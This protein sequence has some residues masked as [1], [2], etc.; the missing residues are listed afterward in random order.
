[1]VAVAKFGLILREI[2]RQKGLTQEELA[3]KAGRSV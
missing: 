2:R 3:H 1:M